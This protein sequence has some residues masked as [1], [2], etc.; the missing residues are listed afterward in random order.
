[1][2]PG[3][4][5][6]WNV[7]LL[8][9]FVSPVENSRLAFK[10]FHNIKESIIYIGLISELNFYLIQVTQRILLIGSQ[11]VCIDDFQPLRFVLTFRIGCCPP[12]PNAGAPGI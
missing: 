4:S 2:T 5:I 8:S 3:V 7:S 11:R 9:D 12:C 6:L 10:I 1:M